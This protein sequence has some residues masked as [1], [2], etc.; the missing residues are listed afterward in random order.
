MKFNVVALLVLAVTMFT[1]CK[2]SWK[3][4]KDGKFE[5][6]VHSAGKGEAIKE[7]DFVT[8]NFRIRGGKEE[9]ESS[10]K[11]GRPARINGLPAEAG[12]NVMMQPFFLMHEGD[13]MTVRMLDDSI[14]IM[15]NLKDK[16][17]DGEKLEIDFKVTKVISKAT[18][19]AQRKSVEE[20]QAAILTDS[21]A[22]KARSASV[23]ADL[24]KHIA[25]YKAGS[26]ADIK[27][28]ASGLKYVVH[29]M[30]TGKVAAKE[31]IAFVYY[32]GMLTATAKQFDSS[33]KRG[34]AYP[35][36]VGVGSVIKGWDEAL[37]LLPEGTKAT[38][39]IPA[40]LAYGDRAM[41]TDI[42]ANAELAFYI[43]IKKVI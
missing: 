18:M 6:M 21:S 37:A 35:V 7:G 12:A 24:A 22:T 1:S 4:S 38:L 14:K 23:D 31:G 8:F 32:D 34:D 2:P 27:T 5:Y 39:F 30:G 19:D 36:V 20:A 10:Y 29:E 9:I 3:K 17:K 25:E 26:L 15:M 40:A 42:P 43:E 41:G 11:T 28:T 13:S 33:F 16:I